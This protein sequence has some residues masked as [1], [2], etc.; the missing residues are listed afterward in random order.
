MGLRLGERR[1]GPR[2]PQMG[3]GITLAL[4]S[5]CY[6]ALGRNLFTLALTLA[7]EAGSWLR[8][9]LGVGPASALCRWPWRSAEGGETR[10]SETCKC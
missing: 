7:L 6:S 1:C 5:C 8:W 9:K 10:V 2:H 3:L 4:Y